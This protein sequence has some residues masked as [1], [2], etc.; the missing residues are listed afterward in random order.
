MT[1]F[2][3][4]HIKGTIIHFPY[5]VWRIFFH[6]IR[7]VLWRLK[8]KGYILNRKKLISEIVFEVI[9]VQYY[10]DT[11]VKQMFEAARVKPREN[12]KHL[13]FHSELENLGISC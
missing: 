3:L 9:T 8:S 12:K 6:Y 7:A 10:E 11:I 2:R 4:C 13:L 1:G 5:C